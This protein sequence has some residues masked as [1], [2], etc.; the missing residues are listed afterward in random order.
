MMRRTVDKCIRLSLIGIL[1]AG[2]AS[3]GVSTT[4]AYAA[5]YAVDNF[6]LA[7]GNSSAL[8]V[9]LFAQPPWPP[10]VTA[11]D[12]ANTITGANEKMEYSSD[13]GLN[14]TAYDPVNPPVFYGAVTV[15]VRIA[16]DSVNYIP[17]GFITTLTFTPD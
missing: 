5:D 2:A 15:L 10:N 14:W 7:A 17:A 3:L 13:G 9:T 11:D 1:I 4:K 8:S 6:T 12:V 16:G